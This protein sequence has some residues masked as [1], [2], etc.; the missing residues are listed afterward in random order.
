MPL[1]TKSLASDTTAQDL[2]IA[3]D[4]ERMPT[5]KV[6][7]VIYNLWV[8]FLFNGDRDPYV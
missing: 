1:F 2:L 6:G 4:T 3:P 5:Q 8:S 7:L